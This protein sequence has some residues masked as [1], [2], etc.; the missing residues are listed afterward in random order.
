MVNQSSNTVPNFD[1]RLIDSLLNECPGN[2]GPEPPV[3]DWPTRL[4]IVK[5]IARGLVYLSEELPMLTLPHGHLKSSNV[6]LDPSLEPMLTDYALAPVMNKARASQVMVAYKS[7]ECGRHGK[8]SR[9][10]DAWSF[11][12]LVL[13][14]LTGKFPAT[15]LRDGGSAASADIACWVNSVAHDK[16]TEETFDQNMTK[17]SEGEMSKLLHIAMACCETNVDA[18][19]ELKAALEK[20]EELRERED[21]DVDH[22]AGTTSKR[23]TSEQL[24]LSR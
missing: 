16:S 14:I 20:I 7:P 21:D 17:K 1:S 18:R 13:E 11:G 6:L 2:N 23:V 4:R 8:P 3:L 15:Y 9:K 24:S 22:H 5:G 19:L 12:I 10:S